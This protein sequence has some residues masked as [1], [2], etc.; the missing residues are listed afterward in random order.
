MSVVSKLRRWCRNSDRYVRVF[1]MSVVLSL[2]TVPL[3]VGIF[4]R[5]IPDAPFVVLV[6]IGIFLGL[7]FAFMGAVSLYMTGYAV[8]KSV[9]VVSVVVRSVASTYANTVHRRP[10]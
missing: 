8:Y 2:T 1:V 3:W 10:K 6:I 9:S 7:C 5:D 4:I